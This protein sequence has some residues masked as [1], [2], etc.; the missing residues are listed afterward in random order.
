MS[1]ATHFDLSLDGVAQRST[2]DIDNQP[3]AYEKRTSP[4]TQRPSGRKH[5]F[6]G[7]FVFVFDG[8]V[9]ATLTVTIVFT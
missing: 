6:V 1:A 3:G 5:T 7:V 8:A 2:V 9:V 4:T